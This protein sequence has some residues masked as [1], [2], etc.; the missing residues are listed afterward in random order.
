MTVIDRWKIKNGIWEVKWRLK[1][2]YI[3]FKMREIKGEVC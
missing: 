1:R 3:N 2:D